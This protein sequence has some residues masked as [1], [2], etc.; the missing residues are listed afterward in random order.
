MVLIIN[1]SIYSMKTRDKMY[2]YGIACFISLLI[3]LFILSDDNI[4]PYERK[5]YKV[6]IIMLRNHRCNRNRYLCYYS[7]SQAI[8][9][10]F[11]DEIMKPIK[12]LSW[13][14]INPTKLTWFK[15]GAFE[16]CLPLPRECKYSTDRAEYNT[17]DVILIEAFYLRSDEFPRHRLDNQK[18]VFNGYESPDRSSWPPYGKHDSWYNFTMTYTGDSDVFTPYGVCFDTES[19][20]SGQNRAVRR[21]Y[22]PSDL[23]Y[24]PI[25]DQKLSEE[26]RKRRNLVK[27]IAD[28][29]SLAIWIVSHCVTNSERERY[30]AVLNRTAPIDV[31]GDCVGKELNVGQ[32]KELMIKKYRF[33]LAFENSLCDDYVTEKLFKT[34]SL[35]IVP[36]VLGNVDYASIL[37][38]HSYIDVR[39]YGSARDLGRYLNYLSTNSTAYAEYFAWKKRYVCFNGVPTPSPACRLCQYLN[40]NYGVK[41]KVKSISEF[42]SRKRRCKTPQEYYNNAN[43]LI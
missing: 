4:P 32:V 29:T 7:Y 23:E 38:P 28:K 43:D 1:F 40:T 16:N 26:K 22:G 37:P 5:S 6:T 27:L 25:V 31:Y 42:W 35:N 11:E 39:D 14:G 2:K 19:P 17:S 15:K 36:V 33:Y 24:G 13:N 20:A 3:L 21:L 8:E 12:I 30:V 9:Y 41:T 34:F 10:H 18:W